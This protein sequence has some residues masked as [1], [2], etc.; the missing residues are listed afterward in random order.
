VARHLLK[1]LQLLDLRLA[2]LA[3]HLKQQLAQPHQVVFPFLVFPVFVAEKAHVL[4]AQQG[5]V[6]DDFAHGP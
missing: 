4:L 6:G 5:A 1:N 2:H 3:F